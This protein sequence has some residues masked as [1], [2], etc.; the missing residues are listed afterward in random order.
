MAGRTKA[1]AEAA[2]VKLLKSTNANRDNLN[3]LHVDLASVKSC[4]EALAG[5]KRSAREIMSR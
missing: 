5:F 4:Q 3:F 2:I 1:K